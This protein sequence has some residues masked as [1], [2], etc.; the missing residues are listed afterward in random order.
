MLEE[1]GDQDD[2]DLPKQK[3]KKQDN[4]IQEKGHEDTS[5]AEDVEMDIV[6]PVQTKKS[7]RM[8]I[9]CHRLVLIFSSLLLHTK[10][11]P[12]RLTDD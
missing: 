3:R 12:G 9:E 2:E 4:D 5:P 11:N 1:E 6:E 7:R 8:C 10:L